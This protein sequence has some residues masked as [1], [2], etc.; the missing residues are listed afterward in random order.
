MKSIGRFLIVFALLCLPALAEDRDLTLFAGGQ[1]PG[2]ITVNEV[3]SGTTETIFHPIDSGLFGLRY[4]RGGILGHEET[5]A[6][7]SK[8][9]DGNS[10]AVIMNGNMVVQAGLPVVKPYVTA[11]LGT[12]LSWGSGISDIGTRFAVNYGGGLKIRPAGPVGIRID[13]R[14]Y[15]AFGVYGQTLK[16]GEVTVGVLFAF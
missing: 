2:K 6:Y 12:I 14:G 1:F 4:G 8:F 3:T 13:A 10:K 5:I 15:S 16:I 11:G 7:A 9:L